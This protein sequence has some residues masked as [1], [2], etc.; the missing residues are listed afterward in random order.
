MID[1][2]EIPRANLASGEQDKFEFFANDFLSQLT[3]K[4]IRGPNRGSD[5]GTGADILVG[6]ERKGPGG[7]TNIKWLVSCKH[8]AHSGKS[9]TLKDESN[10]LERVKAEKCQGFMGFYSTILST[11]LS[12]ILEELKEEINIIVYSPNNIQ[13]IL[14]KDVEMENIFA[15]Y[16]PESY[17]NWNDTY[18]YKRKAIDSN[19]LPSFM[20]ITKPINKN[21]SADKFYDGFPPTME[22][23]NSDFDIQRDIYINENGIKKRLFQQINKGDSVTKVFLIKG[24]GGSGKT[25]LLKRIAFD[26]LVVDYNIFYLNRDWHC[27]SATVQT[28]IKAIIEEYKGNIIILIDDLSKL[29]EHDAFNLDAFIENNTITNLLFIITEHPDHWNHVINKVRYLVEGNNLFS[30]TLFQ[31]SNSE[32]QRLVDKMIYLEE[33]DRLTI[34]HRLM[35]KNERY[36]I[37]IEESKRHFVVLMFQIRYGKNFSNIII[38]EYENLSNL[39]SGVQLAYEIICFCNILGLNIPDNVLLKTC[40]VDVYSG[41]KEIQKYLISILDFN[42]DGY[43]VRHPLI[44]RVLFSHI[45]ESILVREKALDLIFSNIDARELDDNLF[46]NQF[47]NSFN[48]Q[49]KITRLLLKQENSVRNFLVTLENISSNFSNKLMVLLLTFSGM[50]ERMLGNNLE[51]LKKFLE[52]I[53]EYDKHHQFSNRQ[54]AWI[55]HD[56]GKWEEAAD[57]AIKCAESFPESFDQQSQTARILSLNTVDNFYRADKYFLLAKSLNPL[58]SQTNKYYQ[59]YMDATNV[60]RYFTSLVKS[61]IIPKDVLKMLR[62]GLS[63]FKNYFGINTKEYNRKLVDVLNGMEEN[64]YGDVSD[65]EEI[66]EGVN[67]NNNRIIKSKYLSNLGRLMYLEWYHY[68]RV[69]DTKE[70]ENVFHESIRLDDNNPFSHCWLGTYYKE[71]E[72]NYERAEEEYKKAINRA[73]ANKNDYLKNHPLFENNLGLLYLDKVR[74]L[75]ANHMLLIDSKKHLENAVTKNINN[76]LSFTWANYNMEQC[77]QLIYECSI[78][79]TE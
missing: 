5:S 38:D 9:V 41:S 25:T 28:Q 10:I 16:F 12:K 44:A 42:R 47:L 4:I 17:K 50:C 2:K 34:R 43:S 15:S 19:P 72:K 59:E 33:S 74:F 55:Y 69:F 62:P 6:E 73:E 32:C 22:D 67:I 18:N 29:I 46:I 14:I 57:W 49:K 65:L 3:Y 39:T 1:F 64:P 21:Y 51:A 36:K 27:D 8:K 68:Q 23:L 40:F 45:Y 75:S 60:L 11:G 63:F 13:S 52:V 53:N 31:L 30:S 56:L 78:L 48:M 37:C 71:V 7:L 54:I 77:D 79:T 35:T 61:E 20:R 24:V 58:D 76:N 26:L 66:V 70:I